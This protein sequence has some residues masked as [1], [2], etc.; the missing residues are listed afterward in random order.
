M[1]HHLFSLVAQ[2]EYDQRSD[3]KQEL[4]LLLTWGHLST[5]GHQI[6]VSSSS[7]GVCVCVCVCVCVWCSAIVNF[8]IY[9]SLKWIEW[10]R[11]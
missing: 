1:R 5:L 9:L 2:L 6:S 4:L 10:H 8:K 7:F 3:Q 11:E